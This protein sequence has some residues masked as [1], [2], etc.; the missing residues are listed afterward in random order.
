MC[1]REQIIFLLITTLVVSCN[2][3]IDYYTIP[4]KSPSDNFNAVIEIPAGTN[5]KFEYDKENHSFEV[6][7]KEGKDR[8]I[9]F[10]PYLGNY[11]FIPSTYSDPKKGGDGDALDVLVLS[12][13]LVLGTVIEINPIAILRLIDNGEI[14]Y[15]IIA[16]PSNLNQQ[17][18]K[19]NNFKEF[20]SQYP[21]VKTIIE[22]WFLNYNKT[23]TA[24]ID[25]WGDE[26]MAINE[27][28]RNKLK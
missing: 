16:I 21:E 4:V 8:V 1:F 17:I 24:V 7:K 6:D 27:I 10:L 22:L 14:D 23:E 13:S 19:V 9:K 20:S 28:N 12:E 25:G 26:K 2:K 5:R 15:K 3:N 18:I 11:G